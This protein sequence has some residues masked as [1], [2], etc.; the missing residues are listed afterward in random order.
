MRDIHNRLKEIYSGSIGLES[1]HISN[2]EEK[3]WLMREF[4]ALSLKKASKEE[5]LKIL[6]ELANVE[7]FNSFLNDK[8]KTSKR[9]GVEGLCSMI[10]GLSNPY[11]NSR[12]THRNRN[13]IRSRVHRVRHG[14]P[15]EAQRLGQC[16]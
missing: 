8:L 11:P 13:R 3:K 7:A 10:A 1:M 4:E 6:S 9:F 2:Y 14:P 15:R 12:Q 5:K 16:L